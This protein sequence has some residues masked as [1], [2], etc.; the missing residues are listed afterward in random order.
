[1]EDISIK[2][3]VP[4]GI[5]LK[6]FKL[7]NLSEDAII[8]QVCETNIKSPHICVLKHNIVVCFILLQCVE[9]AILKES[10]I[11]YMLETNNQV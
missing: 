1:M 11:K 5:S 4:V 8:M 10:S 7:H 2:E 3:L 6:A 9:C